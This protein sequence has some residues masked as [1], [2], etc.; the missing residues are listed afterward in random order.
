MSLRELTNECIFDLACVTLG[1]ARPLSVQ[2]GSHGTQRQAFVSHSLFNVLSPRLS[3]SLSLSH[4]HTSAPFAPPPLKEAPGPPVVRTVWL[5]IRLSPPS[6]ARTPCEATTS[7]PRQIVAL[8]SL[9]R[10]APGDTLSFSK[11][12][13]TSSTNGTFTPAL[14]TDSRLQKDW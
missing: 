12:S 6:H 5:Q 9:K 3:L 2:A 13:D 14:S 10:P 1:L 8:P 11:R 4:T 7:C